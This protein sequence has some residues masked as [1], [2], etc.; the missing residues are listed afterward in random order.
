MDLIIENVGR[1]SSRWG[2]EGDPTDVGDFTLNGYERNALYWNRGQGRFVDVGH[3]TGAN[4]IED[5]RGVAVS[6]FDRDGRLDLVVQNLD[7]PAVLLMGKGEVG[8]WLQVELRGRG[9]NT[10][11]VGAVVTARLGSTDRVVT[12]QAKAVAGFL[13]SP[14]P[15]LHLGLGDPE[16]VEALEIRW[17]SGEE[18]VLRDLGAN[19]RVRVVEGE[20]EVRIAHPA[21]AAQRP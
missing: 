13:G 9:G 18:Q 5:G 7:Q 11:A 3:L 17:P 21:P 10:D 20:D 12:R 4:R 8:H 16:R 14:S 1:R 15:V 2:D 6:D 19:Q